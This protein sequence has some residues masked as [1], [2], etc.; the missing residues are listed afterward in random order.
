MNGLIV[1]YT[2][3]NNNAGETYSRAKKGSDKKK[4]AWRTSPLLSPIKLLPPRGRPG[5]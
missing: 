3:Q 1:H 4:N 5:I 2:L